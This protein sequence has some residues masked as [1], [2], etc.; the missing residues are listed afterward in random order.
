[1]CFFVFSKV[2]D[3]GAWRYR[4]Q[5]TSWYNETLG[6]AGT[7]R[8]SV[9]A[10][11]QLDILTFMMEMIQIL[12]MGWKNNSSMLRGHTNGTTH[13]LMGS[14]HTNNSTYGG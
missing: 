8:V 1:M 4:T 2:S 14:L 3:G 10:G 6:T 13:A 9:A 7:Q 12:W 11:V 5:H